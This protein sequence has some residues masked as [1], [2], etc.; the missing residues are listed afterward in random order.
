[1]TIKTKLCLTFLG[2]AFAA[3]YLSLLARP[4]PP[5]LAGLNQCHP[6]TQS[7]YVPPMRF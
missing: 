5:Q 4:L 6:S 3:A 2:C 1:M 7:C